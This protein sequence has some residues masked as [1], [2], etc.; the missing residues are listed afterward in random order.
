MYF[1]EHGWRCNAVE[2]EDGRK[3]PEPRN[4]VEKD[5]ETDPF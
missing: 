4:V 2:S 3:E 5:K 1:H